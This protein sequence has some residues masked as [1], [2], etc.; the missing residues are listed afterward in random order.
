[1][2][3]FVEDR[4]VCKMNSSFGYFSNAALDLQAGLKTTDEQRAH[5]VR[6]SDFQVELSER[7]AKY[8]DGLLRLPGPMLLMADRVTGWWPGE[9]A[10][11]LGK[12]RGEKT[13]KPAD[14]FFR[15]HFYSD[16]VQPGSLGVEMMMQLVQFHIIDKNLHEGLAEPYFEPLPQEQ[17]ISW[18]FRGQVRPENKSIVADLEIVSIEKTADSVT[19]L[20]NGSLWVD[21]VRCY[22]AKSIGVRCKAGRKVHALPA[23]TADSVLD[24]AVDAWVTDHRP[25]YTVPVM[26]MMGLA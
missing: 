4:M 11:K 24:P 26:P 20:V 8:C 12:L 21:G 9:G 7:P 15:A 23:R 18:K 2:E 14:W 19:V 3:C 5:L 16:P 10:A 22:E 13:V 25:S 1:I 17:N 6:P